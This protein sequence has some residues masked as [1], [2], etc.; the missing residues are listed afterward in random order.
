MNKEFEES[1]KIINNLLNREK[2]LINE[3]KEIQRIKMKIVLILA[4]GGSNE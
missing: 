2:K 1:K 3:L 4:K